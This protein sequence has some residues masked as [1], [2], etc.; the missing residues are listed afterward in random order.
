MRLKGKNFLKNSKKLNKLNNKE[1]LSFVRENKKLEKQ[2]LRI[3]KLKK[4]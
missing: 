2:F 3:S 1:N 4:R